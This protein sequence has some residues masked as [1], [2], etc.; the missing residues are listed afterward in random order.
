[1]TQFKYPHF[2]L[3]TV[4]AGLWFAGDAYATQSPLT[5]GPSVG[6]RPVMTNLI[7]GTG[8]GPANGVIT[9]SSAILSV[10]STIGLLSAAGGPGGMD[11]DGDEDKAGAYCVW[12]KI[13]AGGGTPIVIQD[14]GPADRNCH[15]TVQMSDAGFK[16]KADV[17][18][19]SDTDKALAKGYT[20]NPVASIPVEQISVNSVIP[21][22]F[23]RGVSNHYGKRHMFNPDSGYPS[24]FA[25][26]TGSATFTLKINIDD[27]LGKEANLKDFNITDTSAGTSIIEIGGEILV[28][29]S[30]ALSPDKL[31]PP[32]NSQFSFTLQPKSGAKPIKYEYKFS[33]FWY[34]PN[35]PENDP[36]ETQAGAA[37]LCANTGGV[38]PTPTQMTSGTGVRDMNSMWGEWGGF[39]SLGSK[40]STYWSSDSGIAVSAADG[41][42]VVSGVTSRLSVVCVKKM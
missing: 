39:W 36:K 4:V 28:M 31:T 8:T 42:T 40:S 37:I 5:P 1:M 23:I 21:Q 9:D 27:G 25:I 18:I 13:P 10:G 7:L 32:S 34:F 29:G 12:Y 17:T 15:Y 3:G 41:S 6:H 22:P 2:L 19:F 14:R 30:S 24:R 33:E 38:L 20:L 26:D 16:I 11:I 35:R